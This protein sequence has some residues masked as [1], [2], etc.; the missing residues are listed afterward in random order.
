MPLK[1][2]WGED[3][4]VNLSLDEGDGISLLP[5]GYCDVIK[6]ALFNFLNCEVTFK[7]ERKGISCY[8][9]RFIYPFSSVQFF[10]SI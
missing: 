5:F 8:S 9:L 10:S 1:S 4:L 7:E 6:M 3:H 2:H